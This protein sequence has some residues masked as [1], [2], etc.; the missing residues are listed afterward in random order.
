MNDKPPTHA[1]I[2]E[3]NEMGNYKFNW[4]GL[5]EQKACQQVRN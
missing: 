5:I 4:S 1:C 2:F 3:G